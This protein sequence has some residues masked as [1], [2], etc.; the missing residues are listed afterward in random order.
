[1]GL[2]LFSVLAQATAII[3]TGL[4]A[5]ELGGGCAHRARSPRL[6]QSRF[7]PLPLFEGTEFQY[8][9]FDYMWWVLIA[10]FTIRLLKSENPRWW[11][12]IGARCVPGLLETKYAIVFYIAGVLAGVVLTRA[13]RYLVSPWFWAG[14]AVALIIFLPNFIWQVRHDFIPYH[15][16][17]HIHVRDVGE[18][19]ADG[20]IQ[21]QFRASA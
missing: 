10:Y 3:V 20:F 15:F 6:L 9:T 16:L 21:G 18:G 2:R 5:R 1:M 13:R 14:I 12:A 4:M 17:Q 11:L 8:T 19:R 7:R